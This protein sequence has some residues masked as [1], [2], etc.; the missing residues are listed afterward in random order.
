MWVISIPYYIRYKLFNNKSLSFVTV[1][2]IQSFII[3]KINLLTFMRFE[4]IY[5]NNKGICNEIPT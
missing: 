5:Q 3:N 1:C 4:K 2:A